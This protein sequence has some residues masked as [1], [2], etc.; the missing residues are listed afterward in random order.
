ML[1]LSSP[2]S[3]ILLFCIWLCATQE[4]AHATLRSTKMTLGWLGFPKSYVIFRVGRGKCLCWL[5]R[6]VGAVKKGQKYAYVILEWSLMYTRNQDPCSWFNNRRCLFH[7]SQQHRVMHDHKSLTLMHGSSHIQSVQ[8]MLNI[9]IFVKL[10]MFIYF[11]FFFQLT[12]LI[13]NDH[14]N[15]TKSIFFLKKTHIKSW[16]KLSIF[17]S[18]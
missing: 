9:E 14:L 15:W 17:D 13:Q 18:N 10:W 8:L 1:G 7:D 11:F 3:K 6:W 16:T 4:S 12:V 2:L 5:T